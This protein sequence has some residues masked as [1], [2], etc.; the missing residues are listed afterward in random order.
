M[1]PVLSHSA[2]LTWQARAMAHSRSAMG[3]A[4]RRIRRRI[5]A[6]NMAAMAFAVRPWM[7]SK[8][9]SRSAANRN[10]A[11][12]SAESHNAESRNAESRNLVNHNVENH[13]VV[14]RRAIVVR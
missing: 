11:S 10:V 12:T 8:A 6:L 3:G 5:V 14:S 2:A 7:A 4:D 1:H 13:N 9:A